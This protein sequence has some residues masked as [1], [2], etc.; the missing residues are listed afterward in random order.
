MT[1]WDDHDEDRE[2]MNVRIPGQDLNKQEFLKKAI[3]AIYRAEKRWNESHC[4]DM[5]RGC[6]TEWVRTELEDTFK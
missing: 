3:E 1:Y 6:W 4:Q 2:I 5:E